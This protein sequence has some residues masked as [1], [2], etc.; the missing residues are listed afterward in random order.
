MSLKNTTNYYGFISRLLHGIVMITVIAMLVYGTIMVN[1]KAS[2]WVVNL[3]KLTGIGILILG[4]LFLCWS[5]INTKPCYPKKMCCMEKC[6]ASFIRYFLYILLLAMPLSGW[7]MATAHHKLPV[8]FEIPLPFPFMPTNAAV[9]ELMPAAHLYL[10]WALFAV[11]ILHICGALKH[12]FVDK[13]NVLKR[14]LFGKNDVTP[15]LP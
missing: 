8:L 11:L 7:I 4:I 14:M 12:H 2:H 10:A 3:H 6:L 13:D 15:Q 9:L 1:I 5:L